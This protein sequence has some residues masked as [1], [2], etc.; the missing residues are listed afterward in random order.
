M[1]VAVTGATGRMGREVID[2]AREA[3]HEV[4]GVSHSSTGEYAGVAI[5][6][7]EEFATLLEE[8][9]PDATIDFTLPDPSVSYVTDCAAAG[10]P[11]VVGTTG[12]S[13]EHYEELCEASK[14]IPVLQAANFARGVQGLLS[15][16]R[17]AVAALPE[18][19]VELTETHHNG[20]RD[21]PSG[22]ANR[23]LDTI[24]ETRGESP[25]VHGREGDAPREEGEI[26]VHAR[27]AGDI[28]GEHEVL[29]AGNHEELRL[30]HRAGSRGVFAA[31]ALDAAEWLAGRSPGWYDF[32]DTLPDSQ[33]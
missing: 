31:G 7:A 32:S 6:P 30:T 12:F 5:E 3:G 25:R 21:A 18:Y 29:L 4:I 11:A 26:G 28:S 14:A 20:K 27:R 22:T 15:A 16:V 10:V 19:D 9:E 17:E 8:R 2:A 13:E 24:D 23:V 1:K 33:S